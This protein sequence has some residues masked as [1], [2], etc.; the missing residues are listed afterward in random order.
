MGGFFLSTL[1]YACS[2]SSSQPL[3]TQTRRGA[4]YRVGSYALSCTHTLTYSTAQHSTQQSTP[5][6]TH[7]LTL[8]TQMHIQTRAH[9]ATPTYTITATTAAKPNGLNTST[10]CPPD[11][12]PFR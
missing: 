8:P 7:L 12:C 11:N 3:H 4:Q 9:T 6:H 10:N 1:F 5:T 2:S